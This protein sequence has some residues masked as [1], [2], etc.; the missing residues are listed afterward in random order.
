MKIFLTEIKGDVELAGPRIIAPTINIACALLLDLIDEGE[1]PVNTE[2]SG[3][4][5]EEIIS[6]DDD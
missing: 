4:L 3:E 5:V 1:A 6:Y 2:I